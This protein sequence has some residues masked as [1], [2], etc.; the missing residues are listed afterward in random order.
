M[1]KIYFLI[2]ILIAFL[3]PSVNASFTKKD[4][5]IKNE[6]I[7]ITAGKYLNLSYQNGQFYLWD[8][9]SNSDQHAIGIFINNDQSYL[10][11]NFGVFWSLDYQI[12][13]F[14]RISNQHGIAKIKYF[15]DE[16]KT[17]YFNQ[18]FIIKLENN[19][20]TV[21]S[22]TI[23]SSTYSGYT[24]LDETNEVF[25]AYGIGLD[26]IEI[27]NNN[28]VTTLIL[29]YDK[30]DFPTLFYTINSSS[31]IFVAGDKYF[32]LLQNISSGGQVTQIKIELQTPNKNNN[33]VVVINSNN[34]L[35]RAEENTLHVIDSSNGNIINSYSPIDEIWSK[36]NNFAFALTVDT[37]ILNI[38][39]DNAATEG[40]PY[41]VKINDWNNL[42]AIPNI[43]TLEEF[44]ISNNSSNSGIF[45]NRDL[46]ANNFTYQSSDDTFVITKLGKLNSFQL[47]NDKLSFASYGNNN[48]LLSPEINPAW[49]IKT[50]IEFS[51]QHSNQQSN[52]LNNMIV[53]PD[54]IV[55]NQNTYI[56]NGTVNLTINDPS[57]VEVIVESQSG[58]RILRPERNIVNYNFLNFDDY[59]LTI[60]FTT[61]STNQSLNYQVNIINFINKNL[62][63]ISGQNLIS[64]V[65]VTKS[66]LYDIKVVDQTNAFTIDNYDY[67]YLQ[68]V[69]LS[70]FE[71][72]T[73]IVVKNVYKLKN[74][75]K[76]KIS[77]E[78]NFYGLK[79][80]N[81]L[82]QVESIYLGF[83]K[84]A[85]NPMVDFWSTNYGKNLM[86]Q[87]LGHR[88]LEKELRAMNSEQILQLISA[89]NTW[90]AIAIQGKAIV[91]I[92][93]TIFA[94]A[95]AATLT[96]I[97]ANIILDK[98][99]EIEEVEKNKILKNPLDA[100]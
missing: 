63:N 14:T 44:K 72:A 4:F 9:S 49:A 64:Y 81:L 43:K 6:D 66:Q 48:L 46:E 52:F 88:Y 41:L 21:D 10:L 54:E 55:N 84:D 29:P 98:Q 5:L 97:I 37:F 45:I 99:I 60:T 78:D 3:I 80:V 91:I 67:R 31:G 13:N 94:I 27:Q 82:N 19:S 47:I 34:V 61:S 12:I 79:I 62:V 68:Y 74:N 70:V 92:V 28:Q 18:N 33:N 23:L 11:D 30:G 59:K 15:Q 32:Y 96:S 50:N 89:S 17:E 24:I 65:G 77:G 53:T 22:S 39:F 75:S 35:I 7:N 1:K 93:V 2:S 38:S 36:A 71:D 51:N 42:V 83:S 8:N 40:R 87:A 86:N 76:I 20:L 73:N 26:L 58:T 90:H 85:I 16:N 69:D 56:T 25:V 95:L 100:Y 57:L